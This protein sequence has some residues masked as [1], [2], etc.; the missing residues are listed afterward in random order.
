MNFRGEFSSN[1][2]LGLNKS[3]GSGMVSNTAAEKSG[4]WERPSCLQHLFS[5]DLERLR[6]WLLRRWFCSLSAIS[7]RALTADQEMGER[8]N[9]SAAIVDSVSVS[10]HRIGK[11]R[12]SVSGSSTVDTDRCCCS[13]CC[14]CC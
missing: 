10:F 4:K 12:F 8:R 14:C 3:W 11:A 7:T 5:L 1:E 2:C 9:R 6:G 13:C